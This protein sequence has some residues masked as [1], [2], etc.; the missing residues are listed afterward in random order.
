MA[1][2]EKTRDLSPARLDARRELV[3]LYNQLGRYLDAVTELRFIV[4]AEPNDLQSAFELAADLRAAGENFLAGD[5]YSEA[6]QRF[7]NEPRFAKFRADLK[8]HEGGLFVWV[9]TLPKAKT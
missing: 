7:P 6:E 9:K 8:R 4:K 2:F 3:R 1:G 5:A